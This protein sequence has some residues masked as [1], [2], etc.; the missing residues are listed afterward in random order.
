MSARLLTGLIALILVGAAFANPGAMSKNDLVE[1]STIFNATNTSQFDGGSNGDAGNTSNTSV[2]L[3]SNNMSTIGWVDDTTDAWDVYEVWIPS[4]ELLSVELSFPTTEDFDLYLANSALTFAYD[5]SEFS[6]PEVVSTGGTNISS[7]GV[8]VYILVAAYTGYGQYTLN[9][10]F[11]IPVSQNDAG[12]GGDASALQA[13][14][15]TLSATSTTYYG[16]IDATTDT[17]DLYNLTIPSGYE[18]YVN[19]TFPSNG[20]FS[21]LMIDSAWTFYVDS[22]FGV[23]SGSSSV[24]TNGT[25][26]SAGGVM[27]YFGVIA[28]SGTG[29][30][31]MQIAL[32]NPNTPPPV[33]VI[34]SMIN[35]NLATNYFSGL[36]IGTNYTMDFQV[37]EYPI[38][39]TGGNSTSTYNWVATSNQLW[40]NISLSSPDIEGT[41]GIFTMISIGTSLVAFDYDIMYYEMLSNSITSSTSA[42]LAA[43]NLTVGENY[44]VQWAYMDN[45]TNSTVDYGWSNFT[46]TSSSWSSTLSMNPITTVNE[47]VLIALMHNSSSI[48]VGAHETSWTPPQPTVS[49][50]GV[51]TNINSTTNSVS[52]TMGTLNTGSMYSYQTTISYYSNGTTIESSGMMNFTATAT[53]YTPQAYNYNTP[54]A[55]GMYCAE[56]IL[57]LGSTNVDSDVSCFNLSYD[58]DGDGVLNEQDLCPQ[59]PTGAT[60]NMYGCSASQWDTDGDGYMDDVDAFV[61]DSTQWSDIDGDGYGDNPNGTS[62]DEFITDPTQWSDL[63]GDGYGDNQSGVNPDEFPF[64]S[65]QWKDTDGDGYGDNINGTAGDVYPTDSSQWAD[66]DG[67]G[68]GDNDWGNNGDAFPGDP[69]QWSDTDDDGFGDNP[70]GNNPDAFP[71]DGTQW[72]DSDGDGYG[73]NQQGNDPDRFPQDPTQWHDSDG[74]GYGDNQNGSYPD[75]FPNDGTQWA[76]SD[77]D[78]YGDNPAGMNPDIYPNDPT[79]WYD[80]DGDGFGDNANG[81]NGD[82][83][84]NTPAGE[85]VDEFGCS[86]SQV[87]SDGDEVVDDADLCPGTMPGHEVDS[88]GCA[89][90]QLDDD[91]DGVNN[92]WDSCPNTSPSSIADSSGCSPEQKDSDGDG[93]DDSRDLCPTTSA[94]DEVNG[95]GCADYERDADDDGID[96]ARDDCPGT[97]SGDEVDSNGC[98]WKQTDSDLDGITDDKDQCQ[99]T[100]LGATVDPNGCSEAQLDED[101]DGVQDSLDD[102]PMTASGVMV[103]ENGC[104]SSQNDSDED[105]RDDASDLCPGTVAGAPTDL[106]GCS[107]DQ[108]DSDDDGVYDHMD[109]CSHT[110]V[111]SFIDDDGCADDQKDSD[112]DGVSDANDAFPN[113]ADETKDTDGDGVADGEDYFPNDAS[114]SHEDE[115]KDNSWIIYVLLFV[116]LSCVVT[117]VVMRIGTNRNSGENVLETTDEMLGDA[118][119]AESLQ[120][121]AAQMSVATTPEQWTDASGIHWTRQPDGSLM[122]FDVASGEWKF[123]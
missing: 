56:T 47:H 80:S 35:K 93:V 64:D 109:K 78:G 66:S 19:L 97:E 94:G 26:Q 114:M 121:M 44:Y 74:D 5:S 37:F 21:L 116:V 39:Q 14:A 73:D 106:D 98:S 41:Y 85:V 101:D 112:G 3:S 12:S 8:Y 61:N 110:T 70:N 40:Y 43:T 17:A 9:L 89:E 59:T 67:D 108:K 57:Y 69:T 71:N 20:N 87:D 117:I 2:S 122:F 1:N 38:N 91:I 119:P 13:N 48:M 113:N 86:E 49:I 31:T 81:N 4:G 55:S 27:V 16:W 24:T 68:Y 83:C 95:V 33:S 15:L 58:D 62:P 100:I 50:T 115:A 72:A 88:Q 7:G 103:D 82:Q 6:N 92:T 90:T 120:D 18:L 36:T 25:N 45:V 32:V 111:G 10:T 22:D 79:Q 42:G 96:D 75:A 104:S 65:T 84:P 63:D 34:S 53:S 30:Y 99:L 76:D 54:N 107:P 23:T 123:Q 60:V 105:G 77:G 52:F 102:C 46:A 28:N 29:N 11:S 51:T 118:L